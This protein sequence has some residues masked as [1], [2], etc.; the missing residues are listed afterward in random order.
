VVLAAPGAGPVAAY[1]RQRAARAALIVEILS[2]LAGH[3]PAPVA[4]PRPPLE[5]LSDSEI[6]VLR[7][8][9]GSNTCGVPKGF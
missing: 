4:G 8:L 1:V 6:R 3:R 2:L 7:Y 9:C 5:L